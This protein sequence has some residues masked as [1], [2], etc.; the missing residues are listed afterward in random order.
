MNYEDILCAVVAI[1]ALAYSVFYLIRGKK[2]KVVCSSQNRVIIYAVY[3]LLAI[4]VFYKNRS[5]LGIAMAAI[6]VISG[7]I[8]SLVPSGY[9][10]KGI[11]L[12]G[13]FYAYKR[14]TEMEFDEVNGYYQLSFT[15][16]GKAHLLIGNS[17]DKEKLKYAKSIYDQGKIF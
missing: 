3:V 10:E 2:V 8:Y 1:I 5:T 7:I 15:S 16:R 13:R 11:Y 12:N 6:I 4:A 14:I 9:D 17:E